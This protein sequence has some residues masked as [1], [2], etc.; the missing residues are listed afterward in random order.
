MK[1]FIFIN[2]HF[3]IT[4][5]IIENEIGLR[6]VTLT[7]SEK[8]CAHSSATYCYIKIKIGNSNATYYYIEIKIGN[9]NATYYYIE[10]KIGLRSVAYYYIEINN[11]QSKSDNSFFDLL[12]TH[13]K[14]I[15]IITKKQLWHGI[16]R[17]GILFW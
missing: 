14:P 16:C 4:L 1:V 3:K 6:S 12:N 5:T 7:L 11:A 8:K 9:S 13:Y 10:I 2:R 15:M 17:E